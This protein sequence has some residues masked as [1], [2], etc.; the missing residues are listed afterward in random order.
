VVETKVRVADK[1][2]P[3]TRGLKGFQN[4]DEFYY[5]LKLAEGVT[6]LLRA[7]IEGEAQTVAWAYMPGIG[8]GRAFGFSGLHFH[9]NWKRPEYRKLVAQAVRWALGA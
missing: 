8:K 9:A 1:D 7:E 5:R 4:K 3:V 6:P 2:H